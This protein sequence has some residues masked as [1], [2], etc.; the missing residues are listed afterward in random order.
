MGGVGERSAALSKQSAG[1]G[2]PRN[3]V[4]TVRIHGRVSDVAATKFRAFQ[5]H[6]GISPG[7]ALNRLFLRI[8]IVRR[9]RKTAS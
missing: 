5:E 3:V 2:R 8:R 1:R 4:P 7:E 6:H 9:R